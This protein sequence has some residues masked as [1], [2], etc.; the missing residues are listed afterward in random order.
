MKSFKA[1]DGS[2]DGFIEWNKEARDL[3]DIEY[4][5]PI[6]KAALAASHN[7]NGEF[8]KNFV[9]GMWD[10]NRNYNYVVCLPSYTAAF[11]GAEGVDWVQ[12]RILAFDGALYYLFIAGSGTFTRGG[13]KGGNEIWAWK[14]SV[15]S[16]QDLNSNVV[17]FV[18]P[19]GST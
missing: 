15:K 8:T 1:T 12:K 7:N 10:N 17:N 4:L 19:G 18:K 9:E 13:T 11:D 16:G 14:G 6:F 5:D 2:T 3:L